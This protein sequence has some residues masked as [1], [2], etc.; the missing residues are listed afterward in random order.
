MIRKST[1]MKYASFMNMQ[2]DIPYNIANAPSSEFKT[3]KIR[4]EERR[5]KKGQYGLNRFEISESTKM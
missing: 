3:N 5:G 1:K 2:A 4:L